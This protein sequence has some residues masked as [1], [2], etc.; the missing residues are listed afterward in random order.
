MVGTLMRGAGITGGV[1]V[2]AVAV[3]RSRGGNPAAARAAACMEA[4]RALAWSSGGCDPGA[5]FPGEDLGAL[6]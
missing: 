1:V 5:K 3:G 4:A 6:E 2:T